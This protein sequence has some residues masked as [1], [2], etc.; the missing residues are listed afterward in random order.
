MN[1]LE[2][3][4]NPPKSIPKKSS[5]KVDTK[6][7]EKGGY[8]DIYSCPKYEIKNQDQEMKCKTILIVGETGAGKTTMLNAMLNYCEGIKYNDTFRYELVNE[9]QLKLD[10]YGDAKS[11]T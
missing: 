8:L 3:I 6:K 9:R 10:G 4:L 11:L 2:P 7:G 1:V 5:R